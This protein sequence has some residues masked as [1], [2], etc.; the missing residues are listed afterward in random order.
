MKVSSTMR[1]LHLLPPET[2]HRLT[3]RLL[4]ARC[5]LP[6]VRSDARPVA[7]CRVMGLDFA[8]PCGIAAGLDKDG[9][10]IAGLR[11]LG[12]GFTELGTVTPQPQRGNPKPRLRRLPEET[13]L[14]NKMGF[15]NKGADALVQKLRK[16]SKTKTNC[17]TGINIGVNRDKLQDGNE[18]AARQDYV[19]GFR[20]VSAVADYV[21][22]NVSSPNTPGLRKMQQQGSLAILLTLLKKEQ[23]LLAG[24][25]GKYTPITVK[26]SP[27]PEKTEIREIARIVS[28]CGMDGITATNTS[29]EHAWRQEFGGGISGKP[30]AA[31]SLAVLEV[32]SELRHHLSRGIALTSVGGI[33]SAEDMRVRLKV[34]A[35]LVQIY[36]GLVYRGMPLIREILAD[37]HNSHHS[38]HNRQNSPSSQN[39]QNCPSHTKHPNTQNARNTINDLQRV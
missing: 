15:N 29:V 16:A 5:R 20:R 28:D 14:L 33:L 24:E 22:I 11:A 4:N 35:D 1:L 6:G 31:R 37:L 32:L 8:N 36:T 39:H 9:E 12:L 10:C 23:D 2:A 25:Q 26:L 30:L 27:D 21:C 7:P 19:A 38:H 13:G 3:L 17:L 34:G 18:K